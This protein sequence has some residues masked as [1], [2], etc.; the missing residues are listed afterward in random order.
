MVIPETFPACAGNRNNISRNVLLSLCDFKSLASQLSVVFL[1]LCLVLSGCGGGGYAGGGISSLSATS[2]VLD[3][4][5]SVKITANLTGT[6]QVAWSFSGSSCSGSACGSLSSSNGSTIT[7]TAPSGITA[8]M[9]VTLLAAIPNTKSQETVSITV[10]PDP[11]LTG[12]P[13]A[14]VV[15][16]AYSTT[17][18]SARGAANDNRS[19]WHASRRSHIQRR[20]RRHLGDANDGGHF[21]DHLA[22]DRFELCSFHRDCQ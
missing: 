17:I 2:F 11:T 14:G 5:Q 8:P 21:D 18:V 7:Y 13:P 12:V 20:N 22:V 9:Q 3:A 1:L 6:Y 15:G 19:E 4:G 16:Q 10:N